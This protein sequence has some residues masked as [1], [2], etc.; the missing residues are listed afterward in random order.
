MEPSAQSQKHEESKTGLQVT[1]EGWRGGQWGMEA[2]G[3]GAGE[4]SEMT[5]C[6]RRCGLRPR[7]QGPSHGVKQ[8][9][10]VSVSPPEDAHCPQGGEWLVEGLG[11]RSWGTR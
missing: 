7:R 5:G 11:S 10:R 6:C 1:N 3:Q 4:D 2:S 8:E 9:S